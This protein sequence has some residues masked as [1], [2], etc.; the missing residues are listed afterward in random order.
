MGLFIGVPIYL[1]ALRVWGT[2]QFIQAYLSAAVI[3]VAVTLI[4]GL[5]ALVI[6]YQIITPNNLPAFMDNRQ[7]SDPVAFARVGVMHNYSYLGGGIGLLFGLVFTVW[8]AWK[9]RR[10]PDLCTSR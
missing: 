5:A 2:K 7:V 8:R 10:N 4:I 1:V 3:V 9:S 6:G